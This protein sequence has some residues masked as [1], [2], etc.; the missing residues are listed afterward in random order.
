MEGNSQQASAAA[1]GM[2]ASSAHRWRS[3]P[4]PSEKK[5]RSW[6][7]HQDAFEGV[8]DEDIVATATEGREGEAAGDSATTP[9]GWT[10]VIP[11]GS[12]QRTCARC[13]GG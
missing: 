13:R 9:S 1:A 11:A 12:T 10:S 8:W 4:L 3:G 6:R 2:S 5:K 7:T